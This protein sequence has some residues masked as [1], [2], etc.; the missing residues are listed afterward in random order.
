MEKVIAKSIFDDLSYELVISDNKIQDVIL[1][2]ESLETDR[3]FGPGFF[4]IQVNGYGGFDYNSLQNNFLDLG[5][6]S[7][8]LREKGGCYHFP[9]VITNSSEMLIKLL[10]QIIQLIHSDQE[11]KESIQGIHLEGPFISSEEGPRGAHFK[12]FV[13]APD[14]SLFQKF[15]D[16]AEG[17]I[18]LITLS[19]EWV[20]SASFIEKC[21]DS[22]VLV[23]IGHTNANQIQIQEAVKAGA[24][25]STHLGN[26]AHGMLPRHPNYL[27]SQLAEDG[28]ATSIIAD[29][30]HLPKEVIQVFKKVKG[31]KLL[32]VSD[33]VALAGMEPGDYET[34]VGGK[35]RL[36]SEG[37]L[38]LREN[39]QTLAG[40]ALNLLQG[41]NFL[42]RN[43]L[44]SVSEA[45]KM[46]SL[47]PHQVVQKNS[48]LWNPQTSPDLVI[49]QMNENSELEILKTFQNRREVYSQMS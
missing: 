4:D 13:Q 42:I 44:A 48:Y 6:I 1:L 47:I 10:K 37:K 11:A 34:P 18:K 2:K 36:T 38:H 27:W 14:W 21:V 12:E 49:A 40:S 26:G 28:L 25:L 16:A 23:S 39:S 17:N 20:G 45:W 22:G 33:S 8:I 24:T 19:P 35:V 5:Q 29:G 7:R 46:A 3:W 43:Q 31:D 41:V 15:Q 30:F 32:L 9:T